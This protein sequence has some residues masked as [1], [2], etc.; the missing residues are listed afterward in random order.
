MKPIELCQIHTCSVGKRQE[1]VL[2]HRKEGLKNDQNKR[3]NMAYS[4]TTGRISSE[5]LLSAPVLSEHSS[6]H[7]LSAAQTQ[8]NSPWFL[9]SHWPCIWDGSYMHPIQVHC[10][11]VFTRL[12]SEHMAIWM[13]ECSFPCIRNTR[14]LQALGTQEPSMCRGSMQ[15]TE[16]P[17][18][19]LQCCSLQQPLCRFTAQDLRCRG[20][21]E[22]SQLRHRATARANPPPGPSRQRAWHFGQLQ[23][24]SCVPCPITRPE[25]P[26][27]SPARG[28]TTTLSHTL[29]RKVPLRHSQR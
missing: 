3:Q 21:E 11:H 25:T 2:G 29:A 28:T 7:L 15:Q 12:G 5:Q 22:D 18:H 8:Y 24:S 27:A 14:L 26:D 6:S 10:K 1:A 13:N 9:S 4:L 23:Q 16:R 17:L 19:Y 20:P